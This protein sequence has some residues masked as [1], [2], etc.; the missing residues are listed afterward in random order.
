[1]D[2][3]LYPHVD[4][5]LL[6]RARAILADELETFRERAKKSPGEVKFENKPGYTG[7]GS[8]DAITAAALGLLLLA[9]AVARRRT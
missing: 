9:R 3:Q 8:F 6:E 7:G 5:T 4:P 1:M 2:A